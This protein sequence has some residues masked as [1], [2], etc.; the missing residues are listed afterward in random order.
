LDYVVF[1]MCKVRDDSTMTLRETSGEDALAVPGFPSGLMGMGD[2]RES[3]W[4]SVPT[5]GE[6]GKT[7]PLGRS[8]QGYEIRQVERLFSR[9]WQD[10]FTIV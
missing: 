8:A 5:A 3:I 2:G 7:R 10:S 9:P 6:R 1:S 4:R